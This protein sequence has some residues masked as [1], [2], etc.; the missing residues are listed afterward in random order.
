MVPCVYNFCGICDFKFLTILFGFCGGYDTE[1]F[2]KC[3]HS[4]LA[5]VG[6][7]R[8]NLPC[9][10][11]TLKPVC[12]FHQRHSPA[13]APPVLAATAASAPSPHVR[14]GVYYVS[15]RWCSV[16]ACASPPFLPLPLSPSVKCSTHSFF[17]SL[18][19][20]SSLC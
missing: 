12:T 19:L 17:F 20:D 16:V 2:L 8:I 6:L 13:S 15:G 14:R 5:H 11:L 7:K 1:L 3:S 10:S 9:G 18:C 4:Q